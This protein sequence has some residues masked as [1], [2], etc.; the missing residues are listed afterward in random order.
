VLTEKEKEPDKVPNPSSGGEEL[1]S[2]ALE[3][4]GA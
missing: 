4:F 2:A 1:V 3:A